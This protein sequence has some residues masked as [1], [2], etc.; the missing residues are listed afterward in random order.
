MS[1][2]RNATRFELREMIIKQTGQ[3]GALCSMR[4]EEKE[5]N[6]DRSLGDYLQ[7]NNN[8]IFLKFTINI[9]IR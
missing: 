7:K 9:V 8:V 5:I 1:V 6:S 2:S 4:I 3:K